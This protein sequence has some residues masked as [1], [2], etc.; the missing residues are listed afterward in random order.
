MFRDTRNYGYVDKAGKKLFGRSLGS[1]VV[2]VTFDFASMSFGD[3]MTRYVIALMDPNA[4]KH[5]MKD[6]HV[7]IPG[8]LKDLMKNIFRGATY[9]AGE[10]I[11]VAIPYVYGMRAQRHMIDKFSPK[12]KYDSD[13][14]LNGGS[15]K[16]KDGKIIGDYQ[17]EGALDLM[18]RFSWYN[19]GT[20]MFR[21][22]YAQG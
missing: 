19:V 21:D 3:Y 1:E 22:A 12:F 4:H 9:A 20:K 2:G 5:W 7:D 16:S 17:L 18:G 13:R 8:G 11:A 14:G 15:Y 6:G 10:D